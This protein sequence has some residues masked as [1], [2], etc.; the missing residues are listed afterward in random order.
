MAVWR[1]TRFWLGYIAAMTGCLLVLVIAS[2]VGEA[3]HEHPLRPPNLHLNIGDVH[4]V[5]FTAYPAM[6]S[7]PKR[8]PTNALRCLNAKRAPVYAVWVVD[9]KRMSVNPKNAF[10][11]VL[12]VPLSITQLVESLST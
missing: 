1:R 3:L 6:Y 4:V 11:Q 2:L 9:S 12:A 8:C 10:L 7:S 5:A